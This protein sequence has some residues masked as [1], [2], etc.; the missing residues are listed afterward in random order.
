MT[1]YSFPL[2]VP[3]VGTVRAGRLPAAARWRRALTC[4]LGVLWL[5]DAA[6]QFQPYM[7]SRAFPTQTIA[8]SG[9]GSPDFVRVP[10]GW[11]AQ[12]MAEHLIVANA[13]FAT[14]QLA[15]ALG[16]FWRRTV[17]LALAASIGWAVLVWWLGEGLGGVLAGPVSPVVGLPGAVILSALVALFLWPRQPRPGNAALSAGVPAAKLLWIALWASFSYEFL[18][19][20]ERSPGALPDAIGGMAGG[21]PGWIAAINRNV[22][23]VLAGHGTVASVVLALLCALIALCVLVPRTT[24]AGVVVAVVLALAQILQDRLVLSACR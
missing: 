21:E 19:P 22:A 9:H 24:R 2:A 8:P 3:R 6:L 13:L 20:A 16:L 1:A 4:A 15:I 18:R 17:T 23:G 10:V 12:L 7:F 11:A 5:L 14:A